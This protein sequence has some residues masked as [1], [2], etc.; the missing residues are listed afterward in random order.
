MK[1]PRYVATVSWTAVER[2]LTTLEVKANRAVSAEP[3]VGF[4]LG[5][6][7]TVEA[8][9][10]QSEVDGVPSG[11]YGVF[12]GV[13]R[14]KSVAPRVAIELDDNGELVHVRPSAVATS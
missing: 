11:I 1:S 8:P 7:V 5:D 12:R 10:G 4:S 14:H 13:L 3:L 9:A 2:T 6:R